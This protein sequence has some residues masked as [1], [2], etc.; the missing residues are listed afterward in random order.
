MQKISNTNL[1]ENKCHGCHKHP[2]YSKMREN[3]M[4]WSCIAQNCLL[5]HNTEGKID[6]KGI[7]AKRYKQLLHELKEKRRYCNLKNRKH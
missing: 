1:V 7:N 3:K 6:G 2:T 5:K 4:D